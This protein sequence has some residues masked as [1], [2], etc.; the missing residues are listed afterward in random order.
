MTQLLTT[1]TTHKFPPQ[2]LV[3]EAQAGLL[4]E[5]KDVLSDW[6]DSNFGKD[7]TDN[8]IFSELPRLA[9]EIF[10]T[11]QKMYQ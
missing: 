3:E 11:C 8:K 6:L 2:A 4:L 1:T 10:S 7:V 9:K 5:S